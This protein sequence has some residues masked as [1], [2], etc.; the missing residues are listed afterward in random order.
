[1]E[2]QGT[3]ELGNCLGLALFLSRLATEPTETPRFLDGPRTHY[4]ESPSYR[5][6]EYPTATQFPI[7]AITRAMLLIARFYMASRHART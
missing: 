3:Q 4:T 2:T 7:S 1:M 5:G 6:P